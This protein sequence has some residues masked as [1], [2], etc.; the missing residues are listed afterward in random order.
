MRLSLERLLDSN[1]DVG[2]IGTN[3][4]SAGVRLD[5]TDG[6]RSG[7]LRGLIVPDGQGL[8]GKV[9]ASTR[10]EWVG[11]YYRADTITHTFDRQIEQEGINR[12]LAAPIIWDGHVLGVIAVGSRDPGD[13]GGRSIEHIERIAAQAAL[14]QSIAD[15]A[16]MARQ[17]AV[18]NERTRLSAELHDGVGALLY[19]IGSRVEGIVEHTGVSDPELTRQLELLRG[20]AAEASSALRDSLRMLRTT[21]ASLDLVA[22]IDGDRLAFTERTSI[23]AE[24]VVLDGPPNIAPGRTEVI[25]AGVREALLNIEKH[26]HASAV[27][28]SVVADHSRVTVVV[29]DDGVGLFNPVRSGIGLTKTRDAA[30]RL[31]GTLDVAGAGTDD[32]T[33]WRLR[34]PL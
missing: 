23:P 1:D 19:A 29:T 34:I 7:S 21:P 8:T 17:L 33:T 2:W 4:N 13:Y 12:L 15:T 16:E 14:A 20:H 32:G 3:R 31:G 9:L 6:D 30:E 28:I 11:D 25:V 10:S 24:L 27:V 18:Q 5:A 22:A 26:A